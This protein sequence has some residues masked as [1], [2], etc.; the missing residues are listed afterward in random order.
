MKEKK[1]KLIWNNYKTDILTLKR[2]NALVDIKYDD[3]YFQIMNNEWLL[4]KYIS[5][6]GI[7][8]DKTPC[9][10]KPAIDRAICTGY[11]I[12]L[13]VQSMKDDTIICFKHKSLGESTGLNAYATNVTYDD[14]KNLTLR[15]SKEH[16]LTLEE[17][18]GHIAGRAPIVIE[19]MNDAY[20]GKMESKIAQIIDDYS[21]KYNACGSIAIMSINP[22]V[23]E[24]FYENHPWYTRIIKGGSF[25]EF[26]YYGNIKTSKLKKLKYL[27]LSKADFIAYTAKDLPSKYIKRNK[28][29]GIIAYNVTS[30]EEYERVLP[31]SDNIVFSNFEPKI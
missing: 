17:A 24:W 23:L 5:R 31:Y 10:T 14:I 11:T 15:N 29:V 2:A 27:K 12:N 21:E 8:D 6:Y 19:I 4:D 18:L 1:N 30:Q 13:I 9:Q 22:F 20:V 7:T 26:K 25:K 28:V 16:I 3:D